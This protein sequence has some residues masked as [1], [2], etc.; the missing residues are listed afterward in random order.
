M[1][2]RLF[3]DQHI[4]IAKRRY[5]AFVINCGLGTEERK[6]ER[7]LRKLPGSWENLHLRVFFPL[8]TFINYPPELADGSRKLSRF[9][10]LLYRKAQCVGT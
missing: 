2:R 9:R 6:I 8:R 7:A 3:L 5:P 1:A 10:Y 4:T